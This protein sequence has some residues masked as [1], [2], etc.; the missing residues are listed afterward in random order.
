MANRLDGKVAIISG[1]ARGQGETEARRFV[2]EGAR[3]VVADLLD[4]EAGAVAAALGR[5]AISAH[6][7][8]TRAADWAAAVDACCAAF[9]NP[10]VLV[11]N[12][13]ILGLTPVRGGDGTDAEAQFR[14]IVDV[15]LVG[16]YLGIRA[17][18]DAMV[19]AGG[20]SI[21]NVS[22]V[23]GLRGVGGM[24][25]YSASK[26]G[27]RGLTKTAAVELAPFAI[28]VNSV[29]PGGVDTPMLAG[30]DNS[31]FADRP[32]P[33]KATADEIANLV[34]FLASDESSFSTGS[35]FVADGGAT[36]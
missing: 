32:I 24:A 25:A 10:T 27:L 5:D 18:A 8:V 2:A 3:V 36:A 15:N 29:H 33:R 14:R 6:L 11:N 13:G 23:A 16:A 34:L 9:G 22:S 1:G 20:G 31:G 26:F 19:A 7:D 17:V 21:V 30:V 35:E 28:R 12:A 4:D